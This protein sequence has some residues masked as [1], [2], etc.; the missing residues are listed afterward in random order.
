[1]QI[2]NCAGLSKESLALLQSELPAHSTL[3]ELMQWSS[4]QRPPIIVQ[5]V[6]TQDEYTHDLILHWREALWLVYGAT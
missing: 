5:E 2:V 6:I 1:M 4:S 3:L